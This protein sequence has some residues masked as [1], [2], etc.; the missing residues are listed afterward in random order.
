MNC[1]LLVWS[2]VPEEIVWPA[3]D[4]LAIRQLESI[5]REVIQWDGDTTAAVVRRRAVLAEELWKFYID[6]AGKIAG[7]KALF[8]SFAISLRNEDYDLIIER[9][10]RVELPEEFWEMI[11]PFYRKA[12]NKSLRYEQ[13]MAEL[14][15]ELATASL[16]VQR[17]RLSYDLAN[18]AY[19]AGDSA[20]ARDYFTEMLALSTDR[21]DFENEKTR[22]ASYLQSMAGLSI[23]ALAP[24]FRRFAIDGREVRLVDLRGRLVLLD[25]WASWCAP[26]RKDLPKLKELQEQ[27]AEKGLVIIGISLDKNRDAL[28]RYLDSKQ[29][30]WLQIWAETGRSD[31]LVRQYCGFGLPTY[32]LIDRDGM[33]RYNDQ[34]RN[35]RVDIVQTVAEWITRE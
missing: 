16:E 19:E 32:Y 33:I 4:S 8:Y 28:T 14:Q 30:G 22:A 29:V 9:Y 23:G 5:F 15:R 12:A 26:C 7:E 35:A 17:I 24:A 21:E 11:Y 1:C 3:E 27:Y 25:F 6:N 31:E 13:F 18:G 34:S 10:H 20:L 2:Q